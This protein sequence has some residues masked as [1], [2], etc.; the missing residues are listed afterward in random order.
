MVPRHFP[1]ILV[2][3]LASAL[4]WL[5]LGARQSGAYSIFYDYD[6][7]ARQDQIP[8]DA[9]GGLVRMESELSIND[10]GVVA[11]IGHVPDTNEPDSLLEHVIAY[12]PLAGV[13]ADVST[14]LDGTFPHILRPSCQVTNSGRI[15]DRQRLITL[16]GEVET[17]LESWNAFANND[18]QAI[19]VA[20]PIGTEFQG[21]FPNASMSNM[22]SYVFQALQTGQNPQNRLAQSTP[23]GSYVIGLSSPLAFPMMADN[24]HF[25]FRTSTTIRILGPNAFA[26]Q[27]VLASIGS[28]W[29]AL[30]TKP[31]ISD[32]GTVVVFC[33]DLTAAGAASMGTYP[34]PGVFATVI[35]YQGGTPTII[36]R[37]RVAGRFVF[38]LDARVSAT[39]PVLDPATGMVVF[40]VAFTATP[41]GGGRGLF[42]ARVDEDS[43]IAPLSVVQLGDLLDGS[44]VVDVKMPYDGLVRVP[45]DAQGVPRAQAGGD[46]RLAFWIR[47]G[48]GERIVSATHLEMDTDE[49]G[50]YDHWEEEGVPYTAISGAIAQY[51]LPGASLMHKDL[52][53][54]VD[55]MQGL[56]PD[57]STL[58][59]VVAAFDSAPMG[60]PDLQQGV[61]LHIV[62]VGCDP[63]VDDDAMPVVEF[64][65]PLDPGAWPSAFD[66]LKNSGCGGGGCFGTAA[67]RGRPD[68][69]EA[70]SAKAVAY[71]YCIFGNTHGGTTSSGLAET[72][73]NDFMVTLG[74]WTVPGGTPDEQAG[75]FMHELGHTL[76]LRHGGGDDVQY[77]PNY[78]SVMN[79]VWQSPRLWYADSWRLDYSDTVLPT[80]DERSLNEPQGIGGPPDR[81]TPI[82]PLLI[83]GRGRLTTKSGPVDWNADGDP[84]D[85]GVSANVTFVREDA[86]SG[87]EELH[88]H[89]DWASLRY[90]PRVVAA[91]ED[92]VYR[93]VD[94]EELTAEIAAELDEIGDCNGNDVRDDEDIRNGTS[95]DL[96]RNGIPD[97]CEP[98]TAVAQTEGAAPGRVRFEVG[99]NPAMAQAAVRYHLPQAM[100]VRIGVYDAQG[101]I[102]QVLVDEVMQSGEHSGLWDGRGVDGRSSAAGVYFVRLEAGDVVTERRVVLL[103]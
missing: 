18:R 43:V 94:G 68:W 64:P 36:R 72:P 77:K 60:N 65:H 25:V 51:E 29:S 103:R 79:Y 4:V 28:D 81:E 95:P 46:H 63:C 88:G 23:V 86:P 45:L 55:A 47:N 97:E 8:L 61:D 35:D 100:K 76:G 66:S 89:D 71:R 24:H 102:V 85:V 3:V 53:V 10:S 93:V 41:A 22:G 14:A 20:Q 59:H 33:G 31:G 92:G 91:W 62:S 26:P 84:S 82:G 19:V 50:L 2:F 98:V 75:T 44:A 6:I 42:T 21:I 37:E 39:N 16:F 69:G 80:L 57:A 56:A 17:A 5:L 90:L 30:G 7:I 67:E 32:D 58:A 40:A 83:N 38:D 49:D 9:P 13:L 54:E 11:F 78:H 34:G 52:Y 48:A 73:G 12:R 96:N 1:S 87:L 70:R 15:V 27:L 101:R 74:G 99:P